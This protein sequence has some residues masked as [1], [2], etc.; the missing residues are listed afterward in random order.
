MSAQ[1]VALS[2][3]QLVS[4]TVP[5]IAVLI[6]MLRN[7]ENIEW[8][9]RQFAFGLAVSALLFFILG[10]AFTLAWLL[11]NAGIPQLLSYGLICVLIAVTA[12]PPF[13]YVL[14]REQKLRFH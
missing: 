1:D 14:Y 4:L 7:S 2:I 3:I 6:K 5:P 9:T 12:F 13:M 8:R 11:G 10:E